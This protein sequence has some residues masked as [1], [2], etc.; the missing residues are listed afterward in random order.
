[1]LDYTVTGSKINVYF[2][3]FRDLFEATFPK[4]ATFLAI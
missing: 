2:L 1:M 3:G 4:N